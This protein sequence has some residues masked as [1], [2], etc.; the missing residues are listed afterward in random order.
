MITINNKSYR[1]IRCPHCHKL[2][3]YEYIF[4]G[5]LAFTCPRCSELSTYSFKSFKTH[6]TSGTIQDEFILK[7]GE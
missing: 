6:E 5:R 7:G 3:C 1:E 2:I 4:A